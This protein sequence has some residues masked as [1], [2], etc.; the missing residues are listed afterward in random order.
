MNGRKGFLPGAGTV[1]LIEV[2]EK[3]T[4]PALNF[5]IFVSDGRKLSTL[6][7]LMVHKIE[8]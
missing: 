2:K 7:S 3:G 6:K 4:H 8:N 1:I 5:L